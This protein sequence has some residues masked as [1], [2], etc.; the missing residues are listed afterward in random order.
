MLTFFENLNPLILDVAII[1]ILVLVAFFGAIRGIKKVSINVLLLSIALFLGFCSYTNSL[2]F[3]IEDKLINMNNLVPA[4]SDDIFKFAASLFSPLILSLVLF[5]LFYLVMKAIVTLI[6]MLIKRKSK[7]QPKPKS[8]VGR[9]FGGLLSL[10]YGAALVIVLLLSVNNN[11]VGTKV[12]IDNSTVTKFVVDNSEKLLNKIDDKLV[13][14]IVI[15]IYSGD[16]LFNVEDKTIESFNYIDEKVKDVV[17]N[18]RYMESLDDETLSEAEVENMVKQRLNDLSNLAIVSSSLKNGSKLIQN[19]FVAVAD[20]WI[21]LMSKSIEN[22]ELGKVKFNIQEIAA[23]RKN[24]DEAGV[25]EKT[26][27]LLDGFVTEI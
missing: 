24:L 15:K 25:G 10:V 27:A 26:I 13:D 20:E 16:I 8:V 9:V 4:G 5:L 1:A 11:I 7:K 22:S 2:K 14:K 3:V 6:T 17:M 21:I 18:T 23:I 12:T 19:N